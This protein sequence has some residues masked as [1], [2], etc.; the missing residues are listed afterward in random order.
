MPEVFIDTKK[1][2]DCTLGRLTLSKGTFTCFTLELPWRGNQANKSCIP[3]GNYTA[4]KI[5]SPH[6]GEVIL[7]EDVEGRTHIQIHA[8]NFTRQ[9]LGCVLVGDGIKHLDGDGIPDVTNSGRTLAALM[10][11]LPETFTITVVRS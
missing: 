6:N 3:A 1:Y 7:I 5:V 2:H 11:A 8:G 9:I 10:A 4:R